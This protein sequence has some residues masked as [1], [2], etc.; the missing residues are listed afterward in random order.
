M[1]KLDSAAEEQGRGIGLHRPAGMAGQRTA[2]TEKGGCRY[3]TRAEAE[4]EG[5]VKWEVAVAAEGVGR[6]CHNSSTWNS[7]PDP[8]PRRSP[9]RERKI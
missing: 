3:C 4:E 9:M 8:W 1:V 7:R 5:I 6:G 2:A